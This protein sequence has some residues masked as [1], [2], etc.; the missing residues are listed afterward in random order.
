MKTEFLSAVLL[1]SRDPE[2]L[3]Q[4]YRNVLDVPVEDTGHGDHKHYECELGDVHFAIHPLRPGASAGTGSVH[5]AFQI[6]ELE[7]FLEVLKS[8]GVTPQYP[9]TQRGFA[10]MTEVSDPDGNVVILTQ[11]TERWLEG[12]EK[13]KAEGHDIIRKWKGE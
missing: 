7:K 10:L 8:K 11:L 4:F 5:I 1:N 3:A 9:P 6:F 2:R 13:R 12:M